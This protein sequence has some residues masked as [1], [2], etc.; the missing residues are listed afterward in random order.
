MTQ[1]IKLR[2]FLT[3]IILL[4]FTSVTVVGG[5]VL[6]ATTPSASNSG[7]ALEIA[8][9]I[10]TLSGDPGKT[11]NAQ[12]SLRNISSG[13]LFVTTQV[14]DFI[15]AGEDGTPKILLNDSEKSS[16]SLK[17]WVAPVGGFLIKP[18]EIKNLPVKFVIPDNASPGGHFGVIRFSARAPELQNSGVSLSASLGTL[19]LFTI[20]GKVTENLS[21]A[22]LSARENVPKSKPK[23]VFE[24]TPIIFTTRLR[25]SGNIQEQPVGRIMITNMFGK[26]IAGLNVNLPPRNVLP[27]SIRRFESPLDTSVIGNKHLFGHYTAKLKVTYGA[28]S[29]VVSTSMGFWVI[30]YRLIA[31][32]VVGLIVGFFALRSFIRRYNQNIIKRSQNRR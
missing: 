30:P 7:Q 3:S 8:P 17:D 24:A 4:V 22:E 28:D 9:P 14:N 6:A 20:S 29:K 2:S 10:L 15:A 27:D 1:R 32:I 26:D 16:Y 12:I 18:R 19:V 25:N 11:V 31:V 5:P 21:I 23:S 13:N